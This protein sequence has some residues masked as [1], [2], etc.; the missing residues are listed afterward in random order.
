MVS[1]KTLYLHVLTKDGRVKQLNADGT[2]QYVNLPVKIRDI[3]QVNTDGL[4]A[5]G[6]TNGIFCC[7]YDGPFWEL[8]SKIPTGTFRAG[9]GCLWDTSGVIWDINVETQAGTKFL[10]GLQDIM[11]VN[12][13]TDFYEILDQNGRIYIFKGGPIET[14][15]GNGCILNG[16]MPRTS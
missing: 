15:N 12:K 16:M 3:I 14:Y 10:I 6:E 8:G 4:I 1:K 2:Y 5:I 11:F 13:C 7:K 9:N